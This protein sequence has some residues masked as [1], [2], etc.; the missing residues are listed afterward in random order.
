[1]ENQIIG[2]FIF[3]DYNMVDYATLE[4]YNFLECEFTAF[5]NYIIVHCKGDTGVWLRI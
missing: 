3:F 1:M 4:E 2:F 5:Y